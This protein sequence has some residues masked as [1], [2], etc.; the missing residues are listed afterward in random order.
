MSVLENFDGWKKFLADR[1]SQAEE[2]GMDREKIAGLATQLGGYLQ[3]HVDPKNNEQRLLSDLWRSADDEE[4]HAMA[5][6]M[7]K[8][9]QDENK[10]P[11]H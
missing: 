6:V 9:V 2:K 8:Y 4:R 10:G 1:V 5:S 3:E 11:K 7:M